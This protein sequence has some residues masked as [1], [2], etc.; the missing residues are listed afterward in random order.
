MASQAEGSTAD[1]DL[2]SEDD[3]S[4]V[5]DSALKMQDGMQSLT[6]TL[7]QLQHAAE[8]IH[9]SEQAAKKARLDRPCILQCYTLQEVEYSS[10][11]TLLVRRMK[12]KPVFEGRHL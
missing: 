2:I 12:K 1:V 4:K 3:T 10:A 8:A 5:T 11:N 6:A 9:E 7:E